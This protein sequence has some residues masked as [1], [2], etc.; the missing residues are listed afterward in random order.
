MS[1]KNIILSIVGAVWLFLLFLFVNLKSK[2]AEFLLPVLTVFIIV[3]LGLVTFGVIKWSQ[4]DDSNNSEDKT[5]N[6]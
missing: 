3:Y 4:K 1:K 6:N 2:A 5:Q